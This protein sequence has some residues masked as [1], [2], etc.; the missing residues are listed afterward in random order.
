M[1]PPAPR[2]MIVD[3]DP[4]ARKAT[5]REFER[6]GWE[7]ITVADG[8]EASSYIRST[9]PDPP[10][11]FVID[12]KLPAPNGVELIRII[13]L[14]GIR[15]RQTRRPV[16]IVACTCAEPGNPIIADA[17]RAGAD[18]VVIKPC[19]FEH[20]LA[21]CKGEHPGDVAI[22]PASPTDITP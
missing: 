17:I 5:G 20:L 12:L 2:A 3:D 21:V 1:N 16:R 6:E 11:V 14:M 19:H 8:L 18:A 9:T 13:E 22:P 4:A 15:S 10:D 7:V